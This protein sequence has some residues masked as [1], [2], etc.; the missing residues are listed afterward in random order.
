MWQVLLAHAEGEEGLADDL[1]AHLLGAGYEVSHRGTV[2]VGDSVVEA[3]SKLLSAGAPV[4]ICGTVRAVGTAWAHRL[5][6]AARQHPCDKPRIF[7]VQME[8]AAYLDQLALAGK[9]LTYWQDPGRAAQ[10]LVGA[11]NTHYPVA[12]KLVRNYSA[13]VAARQY[14]DLTALQV[15]P[16]SPTTREELL[17]LARDFVVSMN[18]GNF[19]HVWYD[20]ITK[21]AATFLAVTVPYKSFVDGK[22]IEALFDVQNINDQ[23]IFVCDGLALAFH[24]NAH[25]LRT[26]FFEGLASTAVFNAWLAF[27]EAGAMA[28]ADENTAVL[29]ADSPSIPLILPFIRGGD[30]RYK[31]DMEVWS[32]FSMVVRA[33]WMYDLGNFALNAGYRESALR[34]FKLVMRMEWPYIRTQH[35]MVDQMFVR[36][37]ITN[38]RREELRQQQQY[39]VKAREQVKEL[40]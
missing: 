2:M 5:V 39:L 32:V 31:L 20:L 38:E 18:D 29:I 1:A 8:S 7:A 13:D 9:V 6:N 22:S 27:D 23:L 11:L 40:L 15:M 16:A 4:V 25:R 33:S 30:G 35:L 21:D 19:D 17:N 34:F 3:A 36:M 26:D 10:E 14:M 37:A 24:V 28:F 12:D